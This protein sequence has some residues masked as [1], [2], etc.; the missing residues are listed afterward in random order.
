MRRASTIK[1]L[2]LA[3]AAWLLTAC[4]AADRGTDSHDRRDTRGAE[5]LSSTGFHPP[6]VAV[7]WAMASWLC[8]PSSDDNR[9]DCEDCCN[10]QDTINQMTV[11]DLQCEVV[12]K[13]VARV[14]SEARCD[15]TAIHQASDESRSVYCQTG[16]LFRYVTW[17]DDIAQYYRWS[18]VDSPAK[19]QTLP[20][21]DVTNP[22]P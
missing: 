2:L 13:R 4:A 9:E 14:N 17:W 12:G 20:G 5:R 11:D 6:E 22:C 1:A 10:Y 18:M 3:S 8:P 15:F 7:R 19:P 16:T 21:G